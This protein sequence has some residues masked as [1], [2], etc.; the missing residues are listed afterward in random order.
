MRT[1]LVAGNWKMNLKRTDA[2]AL[3][4]AIVEQSAAVSGVELAVC[5]PSVY[6]DAVAPVVAG[7]AVGL[8]AQNMY[9]EREGAFT[10]E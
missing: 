6:L 8:G 1:P 9:H 10:G 4:R 3:A 7:S 5:P 2:V